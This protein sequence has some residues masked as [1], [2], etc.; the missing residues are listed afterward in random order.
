MKALALFHHDP[1]H[2]D[3]VVASMERTARGLIDARGATM[4]CFAAAEGDSL[5]LSR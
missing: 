3:D 2:A 5:G 4:S 1:M